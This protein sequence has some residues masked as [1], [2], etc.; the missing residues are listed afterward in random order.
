MAQIG[1]VHLHNHTEYSLL[2][3]AC[4]ISD[5]VKTA[6]DMGMPAIAIT[7]HGNMFGA[8]EFHTVT[9]GLSFV[10][11]GRLLATGVYFCQVVSKTD[12]ETKSEIIMPSGDINDDMPVISAKYSDSGTGIDIK[13]VT[14]TLNGE[15]VQATERLLL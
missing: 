2:D 12:S 5:L 15:Q 6:R 9:V 13:S 3:G 1:F 11:G 8:V 4:R 7:D 10:G 14:V